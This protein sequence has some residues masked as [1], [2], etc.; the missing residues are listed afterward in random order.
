MSKL[1]LVI[2]T[3]MSIHV[4]ANEEP[5]ADAQTIADLK[6]FCMDVAQEDGTGDLTL[7]AFMLKCVN[8]ELEDEGYRPVKK[9]D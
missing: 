3:V 2:L 4:Y 9:L 7:Q 1:A 6:E 5:E 8:Q